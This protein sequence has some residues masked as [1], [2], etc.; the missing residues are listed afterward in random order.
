MCAWPLRLPPIWAGNFDYV[1]EVLAVGDVQF[2]KKCIGKMKDVAGQMEERI[3]FVSHNMGAVLTLCNRAVWLADGKCFMAGGAREVGNAYLNSST[4]QS[5]R[6]LGLGGVR[7]TGADGSRARIIAV[8][9]MDGLPLRHGCSVRIRMEIAFSS[10]TE[11]LRLGIG[12]STI[13]GTRVVTYDSDV[14]KGRFFSIDTPCTRSFE[15]H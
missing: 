7:R 15:L 10:S 4:M 8:E 5:Q 2:Q 13:D 9:W 14:N 6:R 1:D 3:L 12:F 11:D